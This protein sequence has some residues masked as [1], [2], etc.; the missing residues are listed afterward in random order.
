MG[1]KKNSEGCEDIKIRDMTDKVQGQGD[2][3]TSFDSHQD[4]PL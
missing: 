4:R 2:K 1:N 3:W